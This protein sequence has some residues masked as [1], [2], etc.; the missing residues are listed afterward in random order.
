MKVEL[1]S[2]INDIVINHY[3]LKFLTDVTQEISKGQMFIFSKLCTAGRDEAALLVGH[4]SCNSQVAGSS[5]GWPPPHS[6]LAQAT[7][8]CV[9]L[10][11][12]SIIW[13]WPRDSDLF[14]WEGNGGPC[15]KQ[16]QSTKSSVG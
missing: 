4:R 15:G 16:W 2:L 9:P 10:S 14:V 3:F 12:N 11:P 7:Y 5:P 13:Y 1:S 8:T 6:G